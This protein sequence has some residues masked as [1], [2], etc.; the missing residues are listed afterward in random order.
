MK[1]IL[2]V[3]CLCFVAYS[4]AAHW[5][6]LV[7]GSN[8]FWNYRHQADVCH[9][10]Q[11]LHKNGIPDSNII[12]MQY[13]DI[14]SA[15]QNPYKG[16]VFNKPTEA[17]VP[18]ADVYAGCP[19]DYT[20]SS[21][22]AQNFLNVIQGIPVP[23]HKVIASGPED[24]IFIYFSDHGSTGLIAFPVGN[25]L[26]ATSLIQ[27]LKQ[28]HDKKMY[29]KLVFYLEACE[30]GSMFDKILTSDLNI[31]ATTAADP[32][33]SSWGWYCSPDD[34]VNGK[35]I[36]SCLGDEYS[37][38]WMEDSDSVSSET[39]AQQFTAVKNKTVKSHVMQYGDL[40]WTGLDIFSF[41]GTKDNKA[42]PTLMVPSHKVEESRAVNSRDVKL[43]YLYS[44][45]VRSG[46]N[47]DAEELHTE[48]KMR[49]DADSYF[50]NLAR[51]V[52]GIGYEKIMKTKPQS[53]CDEI[54]CQPAVEMYR[55]TCGDLNDYT[56]KYVK[57]IVNMCEAGVN[58][59]YV[60][61][62]VQDLCLKH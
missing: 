18:G 30:S 34:K 41:Q 54:C 25:P 1:A 9:S 24:N 37:V 40:S 58:S 50:T 42:V 38:R 44:K 8:G 35:S 43:H 4:S 13:D 5:A 7:A 52:Y 56:L 45:Y 51:T 36:G 19:K 6:V 29:K 62:A 20:G 10:Y 2:A 17:G 47:A 11:I 46:A 26:Y 49:T 14:A 31:Y 48:L 32:S 21:V 3:L 16:Q 53:I 27:A 55:K 28:M 15:S 33:E 57:T 59:A 22:T 61:T 39:L 60:A 12:V 23:G